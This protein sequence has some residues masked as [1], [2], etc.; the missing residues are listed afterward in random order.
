MSR[1]DNSIDCRGLSGVLTVIRLK[2]AFT[3]RAA[4]HNAL[5]VVVDPDCNCSWVTQALA[6]DAEDI[7]FLTC[8]DQSIPAH[9][10]AATSS[11][12]QQLNV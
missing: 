9:I 4:R 5:D 2:Q 1:E 12:T 6:D 7:R 3:D 11:E 10:I 8:A